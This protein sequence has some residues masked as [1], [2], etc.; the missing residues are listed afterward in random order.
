MQVGPKA[1][2]IKNGA[3]AMNA[4]SRSRFFNATIGFF[5]SG[6]VAQAAPVFIN[7][8]HYDNTGGD[9][10]EAIEIA[11]PAG[12][13]LSGASLVLYNGNGGAVYDTISLS[14]TIL[15]Q[16]GGAGT[17]SFS[18]TGLQNG[19][20]DGIALVFGGT[21]RQFLSYEGSF[22][23]V[24]GIA[25]GMTSTDIGVSEASG[26]ALGNSL[27]L[28]GSGAEYE[29]FTW[30]G[31]SPSTFGA[32]NTGQTF[33]FDLGPTNELFFSEYVEGSSNN[34]ALEIYNGTSTTIDLAAGKYSIEIYFNGSTS[35]GTSIELTGLLADDDVYVV[36][37]DGADAAILAVADQL[38][39][40]NFFNGDDVIALLK[41]GVVVDVFGQIGVDPGS[42]W[43]SGSTIA[44]DNTLRRKSTIITGDT[45][46]SNSFDPAD[47][48]DGSGN[49]MFGDLGTHSV[50][51][52]AI[53]EPSI[54]ASLA[55]GLAGMGFARKKLKA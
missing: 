46:G 2:H 24:G 43:G 34:K 53:P 36:A 21:V 30:S 1:I 32:V 52:Q 27:Q 31:S 10:G 39:T 12:T 38:S 7:E 23:A 41:D 9:T 49:N 8:I 22:T 48:W 17:L 26:S 45:D 35:V 18:A 25:D 51:R 44:M 15:D 50:E 14:G 11:G 3:Q 28:T 40:S 19:S 47:E 42:A 55:I 54:L 37:D 16:G 29:D 6:S 33:Q 5:L 13:N 20:P 4:T